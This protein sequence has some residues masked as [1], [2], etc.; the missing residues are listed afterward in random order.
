MF[1]PEIAIVFVENLTNKRL[2]FFE[3]FVSKRV[4]FKLFSPYK[5][6]SFIFLADF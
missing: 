5:P 4:L 1:F 3:Q 2:T 6:T